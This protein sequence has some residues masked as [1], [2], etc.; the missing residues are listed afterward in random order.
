MFLFKV[1]PNE[2]VA[3]VGATGS[4]KTTILQLIVRNYDIQKGANSH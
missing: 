3:F 2:T 4:G 1:E